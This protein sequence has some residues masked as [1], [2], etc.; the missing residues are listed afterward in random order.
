MK[1]FRIMVLVM[2]LLLS[3]QPLSYAQD[4]DSSHLEYHVLDVYY[5]D[6]SLI[7]EGF[8]CNTGN[9]YINNIS[10]LTLGVYDAKGTLLDG[11]TFKNDEELSKIQLEPGHYVAWSFKIDDATQ[12]DITDAEVTYDADYDDSYMASY[13]SGTHIFVNNE[14]LKADV[15]PVIVNGRTLVP[16]RAIF[17]QMGATVTYDQ[18][19]ATVTAKKDDIT[20]IHK[21][22]T[23]VFTVNG[24]NVTFD[25]ASVLEKGRTMVPLRVIAESLKGT[26]FWGQTGN[27]TTIGIAN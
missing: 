4:N 1:S 9:V 6:K 18:Q 25:A 12:G 11:A 22:G 14:D 16:M 8:L 21:I 27:E 17:E 20:L 7:V 23:K 19:T 24:K 2:F 3:L 5:K 10:K 15:D 26:V 13:Q